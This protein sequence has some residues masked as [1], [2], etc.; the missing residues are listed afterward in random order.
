M[1]NTYAAALWGGG[2]GAP[3]ERKA[4]AGIYLPRRAQHDLHQLYANMQDRAGQVRG[5]AG[6]TALLFAHM[7]GSADA[8]K[9]ISTRGENIAAMR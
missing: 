2:L 8:A 5:G 1:S 9:T 3:R 6:L 7:L 4:R